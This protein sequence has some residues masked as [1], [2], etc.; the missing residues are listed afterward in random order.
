MR[1]VTATVEQVI[2]E[3]PGLQRV[4]TTSGRAYV[5][6]QLTGEVAIGD[7]VVINT[8]AV[9]LALGT[10]GWHFVHWNLSRRE[11]ASPGAG[12]IMK[13]RYTSLQSDAGST[14]ERDDYEEPAD[15]G[16]MPV[17]ACSVHSQIAPVAAAF[18][19]RA[20]GRRLAYVMTDGA[21]LPLALSDLVHQL[22]ECGLIAFT[23][24]AGHAF[25][26]DY[27]AVSVPSALLVAK[28]AGADAV[29][30]GMGPGV[31]GT[32]TEY[33][34]TAVEVGQICVATRA[35]NGHPIVAVRFSDADE[36]TRHQ[37]VSHHTRAALSLSGNAQPDV[38]AAADYP[39]LDTIGLLVDHGLE[40]TTMGRG[41]WDDP[42]FFR[43]AGAAGAAAAD[44]L[45]R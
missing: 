39:D 6:T 10:G 43:W 26:G 35:L 7:D 28:W 2:S 14:E 23:V 18:A 4:R 44:A 42:G 40:V 41:Y 5:L 34:H 8:T 1:F 29:I 17:V 9:D 12:H 13:L 27:E 31:V 11:F 3:R 24:T 16:S 15:L 20:P 30:C 45:T 36:R 32:G 21:A 38:P 19:D 25:G 33:G 37:R 22:S